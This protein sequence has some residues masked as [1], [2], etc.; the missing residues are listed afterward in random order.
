MNN[1]RLWAALTALLG[2]VAFAVSFSFRMLPEVTAAGACMT[3]GAVI[4]FEFARTM[5]D[6]DKVFGS[7]GSECRSLVIA[8]MDAVNHRDVAVFIPA[9]TL[10]AVFAALFLGGRAPLALAAVAAALGA[11]AADWVETFT[12]LAIT[13]DLDGAAPLLATSS[14]AAWVKFGLLAVHG[15]LLS[16]V[17]LRGAP[18]RWILGPTLLLPAAGTAAAFYDAGRFSGLM[19]LSF[20]VA[21]LFLLLVAGKETVWVRK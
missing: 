10:F 1:P 12:L 17:C 5:A 11:A 2:I 13:R 4:A 15:L 6:I 7:P 19:S 16:A 20:L 18:R 21:W 8:G 9:Y 14:T 3:D